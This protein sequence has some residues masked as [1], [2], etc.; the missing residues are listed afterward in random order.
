MMSASDP[1][2]PDMTMLIHQQVLFC[3][4]VCW[5]VIVVLVPKVRR[6]GTSLAM[7]IVPRRVCEEYKLYTAGLRQIVKI[8]CTRDHEELKFI[9]IMKNKNEL[10]HGGIGAKRNCYR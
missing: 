6:I 7:S 4:C 5:S 9:V 2:N 3:F 1:T 8:L 10:L